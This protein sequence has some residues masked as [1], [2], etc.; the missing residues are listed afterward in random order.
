M[1]LSGQQLRTHLQAP[2]PDGSAFL[3]DV[4]NMLQA[5][6][7]RVGN[8]IEPFRPYADRA[9]DQRANVV[10][11]L[12]AALTHELGSHRAQRVPPGSTSGRVEIT[13]VTVE[14]LPTS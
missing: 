5:I 12:P 2:S 3:S 7:G 11:T 9:D 14:L 8:P 13:L 6:S 10:G 1:P 4:C